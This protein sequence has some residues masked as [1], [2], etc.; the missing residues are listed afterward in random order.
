LWTLRVEILGPKSGI[1]ASKI[2]Y[3]IQKPGTHL[4]T[5]K[6]FKFHALVCSK[7]KVKKN[8]TPFGVDR[9]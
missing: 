9:F 8:G 1:L 5:T 7:F 2:R 3:Q 6:K 4:D